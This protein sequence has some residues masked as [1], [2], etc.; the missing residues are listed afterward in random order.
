MGMA[1][2]MDVAQ[3]LGGGWDLVGHNRMSH[4]G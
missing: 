1:C 4:E 3:E 2:E